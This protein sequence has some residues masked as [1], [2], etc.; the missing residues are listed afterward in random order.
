[1]ARARKSL[2]EGRM[3]WAE[4]FTV[5]SVKGAE[6]AEREDGQG[7]GGEQMSDRGSPRDIRVAYGLRAP[8]SHFSG[9]CNVEAGDKAD[10]SGDFVRRQLAV[11]E[12]ENFSLD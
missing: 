5:N 12:V 4:G 11:T 8:A 7:R 2:R 9:G 6:T 1:L 10:V 3:G